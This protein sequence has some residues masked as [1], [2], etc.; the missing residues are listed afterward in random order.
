MAK[1]KLTFNVLTFDHP[2]KEF[3]FYFYKEVIKLE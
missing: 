3:T 2:S 1:P